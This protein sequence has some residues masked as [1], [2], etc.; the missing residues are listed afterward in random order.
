VRS[1]PAVRGIRGIRRIGRIGRIGGRGVAADPMFQGGQMNSVRAP[2]S[3][4]AGKRTLTSTLAIIGILGIIVGLL[5][6]VAARSLPS[7]M[8][9]HVHSGHHF[10]R[11]GLSI[12]VGLAFLLVAWRAGRGRLAAP[13]R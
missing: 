3:V 7:M 10:V 6:L 12:L 1:L 2:G 8:V 9:G 11:A 5:Y 13:G 4:S